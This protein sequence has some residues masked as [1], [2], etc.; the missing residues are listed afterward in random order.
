MRRTPQRGQI[1]TEQSGQKVKET[2]GTYEDRYMVY[3]IL[4]EREQGDWVEKKRE[5][6]PHRLAHPHK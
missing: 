6:I 2:V 3:P 1:Y 4:T 5:K